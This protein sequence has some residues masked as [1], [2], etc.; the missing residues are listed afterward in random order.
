[1]LK[2]QSNLVVLLGVLL[3]IVSCQNDETPGEET[4]AN[5][6]TLFSVDYKSD[7]FSG[8]GKVYIA[9]YSK[10][11]KLLNY[12]SLSDSTKWEL[13]GKYNENKF[14]VLYF[15]ISEGKTINVHHIKNIEVGQIFS[16]MGL[17]E[18]TYYP[19]KISKYSVKV[20]DFGNYA[21][22][23]TIGDFIY[24]SV[25]YIRQPGYAYW[26]DFN[27]EKIENGYTYKTFTCSDNDDP[28]YPENGFELIIF[29]KGTN[30]PY[31][32]YIDLK[33]K[34]IDDLITLNKSDF[35][36]A[37]TNILKVNAKN[38]EFWNTFMYTYNSTPG[39]ED[40]ITSFN[41]MSEVGDKTF[42]IDSD[43]V[44]PMSYWKFIYSAKKTYTSYSIF[45]NKAIPSE[46]DVQPLTGLEVT[47]DGNDFTLKHADIFSGR[48]I[49]RS[50]I[51]FQKYAQDIAFYYNFHFDGTESSGSTK[52]KL[53]T[54][55]EEV[56][57][58]INNFDTTNSVDWKA[59]RYSQTYTDVPKN[60]VLDYLKYSLLMNVDNI[61]IS[62]AQYYY[63]TFSKDF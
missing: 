51:S 6:K 44:L 20:E 35:T 40:I 62:D 42:Y 14:D 55:P 37:K 61:K 3:S 31:I 26:G 7:R 46:I 29:E 36:K 45:S 19:S 4:E 1:M 18:K 21:G 33:D 32:K 17:V 25:P 10:D 23:N 41:D 47:K 59:V 57:K 2:F 9:A 5:S 8:N 48:E 56:L 52:L 58:T 22:N 39:R 53:F 16:E 63:E 27:W 43:A 34:K 30:T 54:L 11:G 60:S 12:G 13:K 49:K 15:N 28:D 38:S 50:Y 24:M